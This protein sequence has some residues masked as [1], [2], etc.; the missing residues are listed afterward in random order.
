MKVFLL[1]AGPGDPG[2]LTLKARDILSLA[3]VIV[4]DALAN[5]QL[6]SLAKEDAEILYVGKIAGNHAL[7]QDEINALLIRKAK[8]KKNVARLKGGDPYIFG[9]GGEEA[10]ALR[11]AGIPFEEVPGISSTIAAPAYAGIPLT[12]RDLVSQVTFITGHEKGGKESS[13]INWEAL[14]K[15]R[16]TLVFV[17]GMK[18]LPHIV[19][20]LL[21]SGLSPQTPAALIYRGTTSQQRSLTSPLALL[22]ARA[23]EEGF[24]NPSVIVVGEVVSL[25][26]KLNWFEEKPLFGRSIVVTRAR[27]QASDLTCALTERGAEVIECPTI[28]IAPLPDYTE[29]DSAIKNL[30]VYQWIIFTSVNGVRFFFER[31]HA[32]GLDSRHLSGCSFCTIGPATAKALACHGIYADLTPERYVAESLADAFLKANTAPARILLPRASEAR[33]VLPDRLRAEAM[34][35]DV[36]PCYRTV[37]DGSEAASVQ[38]RLKAGT[39]SCITFTSSSTVKNFLSVVPKELLQANQN[40]R[41]AAIGPVTA[42][43]IRDAGLTCHIEAEEYTIPALVTAVTKA[44]APQ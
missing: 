32:L 42:R 15:S 26:T 5:K 6:L 25:H 2:L 17:M 33:D 10:E 8:E 38:E 22:P 30:A 31:L 43:T 36:V 37:P 20:R 16:A 28:R 3:D 9:R 44:F 40:V 13:N 23:K 1:G 29:L 11:E 12:H 14:A 19:E 34:T 27:E 35:V 24:T 7:P 39:L 21:H 4:Y 18:N 41:L